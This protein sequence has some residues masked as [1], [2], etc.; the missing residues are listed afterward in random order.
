MDDGRTGA[1]GEL[2]LSSVVVGAD[3]SETIPA[4]IELCLRGGTAFMVIHKPLAVK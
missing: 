3:R 2:L 4:V 1:A